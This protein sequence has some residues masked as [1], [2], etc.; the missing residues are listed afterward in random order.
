MTSYIKHKNQNV[1]HWKRQ[2]PQ[3]PTVNF[4]DDNSEN[5]GFELSYDKPSNGDLCMQ[6]AKIEEDENIKLHSKEI[7]GDDDLE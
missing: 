6:C 2:C 1:W 3:Y 7:I 4:S 5:T